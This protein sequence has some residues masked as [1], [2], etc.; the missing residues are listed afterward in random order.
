MG[1]VDSA[2]TISFFLFFFCSFPPPPFG[3][4]E[5]GVGVGETTASDKNRVY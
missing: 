5:K 1:R 2:M 4:E 3:V